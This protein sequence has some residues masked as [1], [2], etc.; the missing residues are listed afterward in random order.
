MQ[1]RE[2]PPLEPLRSFI[3]CIWTLEGSAASPEGPQRILPDGCSEIVLNFA[4]RFLHHAADGAVRPQPQHL[5]VG[6]MRGH[7][8]IQPSGRI[9]LL[10]V[11]FWPGGAH[12]FFRIPQNTLAE[13]IFDL[14]DLLGRELRELES[15]AA[16]PEQA[17]RR[18]SLE[19]VLLSRLDESGHRSEPL[20]RAVDQIL[21]T[22]GRVSIKALAD[23]MGTSMRSLDR[24]FNERV[25]L[26]PKELCRIVR[27][28]RLFTMFE[29]GASHRQVLRIALDCGYYDQSHFIRDFKAFAGIEPT[30]Y[31]SQSNSISDHF[32]HSA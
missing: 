17:T 31:F 6:Q 26:T 2:F 8:L 28:Q 5:F 25:G 4:D 13:N 16:R 12:P 27:F 15:N 1:Y 11:R 24:Q 22:G 30:S 21:G 29:R 10:G 19:A 14:S 7:M 20:Q 3:K 9:D 32:T 18:R 23:N